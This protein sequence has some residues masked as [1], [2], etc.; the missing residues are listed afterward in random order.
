MPNERSIQWEGFEHQHVERGSDWFWALGIVTISTALTAIVLGNILF[1]LLIVVAGST[2][3]LLAKKPPR[4]ATFELTDRGLHI[5]ET[6]YPYSIIH[7]FWI[8]EH[9]EAGTTLLVDTSRL[10]APHL[11]IPIADINP[12]SIREHLLAYDIA[13]IELSEPLSH[14]LL[15]FIGF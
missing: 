9:A 12:Q 13:E 4:I 2:L 5:N 7:G 15:E 3:G 11:V 10:F 14:K 8:D 6:L 1:A